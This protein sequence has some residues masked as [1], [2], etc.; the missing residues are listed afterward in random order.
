MVRCLRQHVGGDAL[1]HLHVMD[2]VAAARVIDVARQPLAC[3]LPQLRLEDRSDMGVGEVGEAEGQKRFVFG[4]IVRTRLCKCRASVK[5]RSR[6]R[7]LLC[8]RDG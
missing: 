8:L 2:A 6:D 3:Q 4:V 5:G 7:S 1:Q